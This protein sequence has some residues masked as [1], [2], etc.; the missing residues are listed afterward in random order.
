MEESNSY[1]TQDESIEY[2]Y[3]KKSPITFAKLNKY[4][5]I[6]FLSPVFCMGGNAIKNN[7]FTSTILMETSYVI[8]GL[9]YFII[10]F[11][12]KVNKGK[13]P[14]SYDD[15][16]Y[17]YNENIYNYKEYKLILLILLMS[18]LMVINEFLIAFNSGKYL[19]DLRA[20]YLIF[21]PLFSKFILKENIYKHHYL[22]LIIGIIGVIFL[23][24]PIYLDKDKYEV[25][26]NILN[27]V[28]GVCFPLFFVVIRYGSQKY[29]TH[30]LKLTFI[31]G[32][33]G[34]ILTLLGFFIYSFVEYGELNYFKNLIDFSVAKN[35]GKAK[36]FFTL[37]SLSVI[38][39]RVL[40][41][42]ALFYFSP[43]LIMVTDIISPLLLW[44]VISIKDGESM[45]RALLNS[46][47]YF[48]VLLS[49][50]IY[51]EIIICNL[52]NEH[53]IKYEYERKLFYDEKHHI[54]PDF[55]IILPDGKEIYWE[56]VGMLGFDD[57]DENWARKLDIYKKYYPGQM[58]KTYE[59]GVLSKDAEKQIE[60]IEQVKGRL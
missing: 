33:F 47:G 6:P 1:E 50:L 12:L 58:I 16:D 30:P 35:K 8:A 46:L 23:L 28:V 17:I 57:Y 13:E 14:I 32:L 24:V 27:S 34:I 36:L 38:I 42:L 48:I 18:L 21:I 60:Y 3:K 39:M 26:P 7:E 53:K 56:H 51:N 55:T 29:Y 22:S 44:I 5:L 37:M 4:F 41:F 52:L 45:P 19:V 15:I 31:F 59:S 43:T 9:F 49:T 40:T 10:H 11:K 25:M 2:E 54:E 20:Y